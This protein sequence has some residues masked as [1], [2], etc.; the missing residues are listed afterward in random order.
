MNILFLLSEEDRAEISSEILVENVSLRSDPNIQNELM[1]TDYDTCFITSNYTKVFGTLIVT[2]IIKTLRLFTSTRIHYLINNESELQNNDVVPY[3][4]ELGIGNITQLELDKIRLKDFQKLCRMDRSSV[5]LVNKNTG[6]SSERL[7]LLRDELINM[8]EEEIPEYM[9]RN[10]G[11]ILDLIQSYTEM[12]AKNELN[13]LKIQQLYGENQYLD[14]IRLENNGMIQSLGVKYK[15]ARRDLKDL[16]NSILENKDKIEEYNTQI[17]DNTSIDDPVVYLDDMTPPIIYI[18]EIE[19][20]GFYNLFKSLIYN[21]SEVHGIYC[22]SI[23]LERSNRHFYNPYNNDGFIMVTN[24]SKM[25]TIIDND[26]L[27]RYGN[28]TNLLKSI[29]RP[30]FRTE[31]IL[32][33]DRTGTEDLVVDAPYILPFYTGNYKDTIV[34]LDI[35]DSSWISPFEGNWEGIKELLNHKTMS[36]ESEIVYNAFASRHP[37]IKYI[38]E[39]VVEPLAEEY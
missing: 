14:K 30:E 33:F 35:N 37:L 7:Q 29:S 18:K 23:I 21:L 4:I 19:D 15:M 8:T 25:E 34:N 6:M 11:K 22:K 17:I 1:I 38:V 9:N 5:G 2:N 36:K 28:P 13:Q 27:V 24:D 39:S 3:L 16:R 26:K 20:I 10:K 12:L 32:I 31:I